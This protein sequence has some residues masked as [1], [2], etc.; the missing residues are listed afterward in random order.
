VSFIHFAKGLRIT[1]DYKACTGCRICEVFCSLKK[2]KIIN[3]EIS[4]IKIYTFFPEISIPAICHICDDPKPCIISC[5][6]KPPAIYVSEKTGALKVD[7]KKCNGCGKCVRS[8]PAKA[9]RLDPIKKYAIV[10]DLCDLDP[11]CIGYCSALR[12]ALAV[13]PGRSFS[14]PPHL[15]AREL[16]SNIFFTT[17]VSKDDKG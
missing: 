15:I 12:L 2:E 13:H 16:Q 9:I 1:I 14:K 3:P 17:T 10:C 6:Q 11:A 4:R 7:E 8:C 5:P